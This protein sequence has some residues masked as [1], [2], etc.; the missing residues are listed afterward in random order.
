MKK[1]KNKFGFRTV[2]SQQQKSF[3]KE[4]EFPH[5]NSSIR[6]SYLRTILFNPTKNFRANSRIG[7]NLHCPNLISGDLFYLD[8]LVSISSRTTNVQRTFETV[9]ILQGREC[10]I[11][12][13]QHERQC[14]TDIGI[15]IGIGRYRPIFPISVSAD[16]YRYLSISV[17]I[18]HKLKLSK[19]SSEK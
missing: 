2:I 12:I 5:M 11:R 4:R 15:G 19:K 13:P 3:T 18:Y 16:I 9:S 10:R 8:S 17:P 6:T 7:N 1:L 14:S